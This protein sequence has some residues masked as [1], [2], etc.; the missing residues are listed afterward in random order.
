[1]ATA[2][3]PATIVEPHPTQ[4]GLDEA[5]AEETLQKFFTEV[6]ELRERAATYAKLMVASDV[7]SVADLKASFVG[8]CQSDEAGA[9]LFIKDMLQD[10]VI[11]TGIRA[12]PFM[13]ACPLTNFF[14]S[15]SQPGMQQQAIG[16][17]DQQTNITLASKPVSSFF[18][19]RVV[20]EI[21][22]A[23][24]P[25]P[26]SDISNAAT[27]T[28]KEKVPVEGFEGY[29]G[30]PKNNPL[31]GMVWA[32]LD[33][34]YNNGKAIVLKKTQG[35]NEEDLDATKEDNEGDIEVSSIEKMQST[36]AFVER[37]NGWRLEEIVRTVFDDE[38]ANGRAPSRDK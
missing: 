34:W 37:D 1:V 8:M 26:S 31:K 35:G 22:A 27:T 18:K 29:N 14:R 2:G 20:K 28:V 19:T 4:A 30:K 21:V 3:D 7:Y 24:E 33:I 17:T 13:L 11:R 36:A 38:V 32:K 15:V 23:Q 16:E 12:N 10:A 6:P 25:G 9:R 5:E